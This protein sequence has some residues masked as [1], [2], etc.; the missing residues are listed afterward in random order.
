[1]YK[2]YYPMLFLGIVAI[3]GIFT[4]VNPSYT[5]F[6]LVHHLRTSKA[7]FIIAEPELLDT[8]K[9]AA[10]ECK[11]ADSNIRIFDVHGQS[12]PQGYQSWSELL[13]HGEDDWVRFN[14]KELSS[15]TPAAL[16]FS[17]GTTGLPKAA[18]V[19]H[20]NLVAQHTLAVE[21]Q[22]PLYEVSQFREEYSEG[23]EM[24]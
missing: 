9:P 10:R 23:N 4:G 13:N 22:P 3:G 8:I 6:E 7:K 21:P 18:V 1:V 14:N 17:S 12:I 20:Y 11:I 16:L 15:S 19:S 5:P 24:N 2:L